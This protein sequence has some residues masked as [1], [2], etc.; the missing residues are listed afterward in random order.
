[1]R[2]ELPKLSYYAYHGVLPQERT[3]GGHFT[4]SLSLEIDD[5]QAAGALYA[6]LLENTVNYAEVCEV[7]REEMKTPSALLE[8]VAAR[9]ARTLLRR[10]NLIREVQVGVT[11]CA[12]PI[13]GFDGAGVTIRFQLRRKLVAWD[14]DGTM[15]DTSKGIVQTMK[16]TFATCQL[17]EP[18][19]QAIVQT[20]GLPLAESIATL[21]GLTGE[22]LAQAVAVYRQLFE[23]IG[24][25]EVALFPGIAACIERQHR[26]GRIIGIATSRSHASV[27]ALCELLGIGSYIDCVV[28]ADDAA[29]C[30]PSPHHLLQLCREVNVLPKD[31]VMIGDTTFDILMGKR[32]GATCIG[33]TWGNHSAE[34]LSDA[35]ADRIVDTAEEI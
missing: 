2:I 29:V 13:P 5:C 4:V 17:P 21:S 23:Q 10:F 24:N 26:E 1:M 35:G 9:I 15:A 25:K 16:A 27:V 33:V 19:E 18:T 8:H 31:T 12:P 7:V 11:K 28:A 22:A 14:F 34:T 6:D 30:K 3:V 20:I 32:A